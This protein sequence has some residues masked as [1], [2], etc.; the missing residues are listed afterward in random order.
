MTTGG[1]AISKGDVVLD[2]I[3][4]IGEI[5][6]HG[7]AMRPGKPAGAGIEGREFDFNIVKRVSQLKIPSQLGRTD[8]IRAVSVMRNMQSMC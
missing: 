8:F 5:L 7:V 2:V 4:E 1:T 6:F 3:D